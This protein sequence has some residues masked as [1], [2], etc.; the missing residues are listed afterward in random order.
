MP[1]SQGGED[2]GIRFDLFQYFSLSFC[3]TYILHPHS[4][5]G[6]NIICEFSENIEKLNYQ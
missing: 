6:L 4:L 1:G 2:P 5:I 3:H